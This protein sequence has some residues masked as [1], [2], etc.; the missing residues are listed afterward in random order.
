MAINRELYKWFYDHVWCH[1]YDLVV[2]WCFLPLGGEKKVRRKLVDAIDLQTA[3][4]ILDMCCGTGSTTFVL[5]EHAGKK[6][7][8]KAIDLSQGQ[9]RVA[10]K[11]NR[12]DNISF[13]AM[14]SAHTDFDDGSFD[15]VVIAH[16]LHE[17]PRQSRISV[18]R[19]A[20]RV[21]ND[22]GRLVVFEM[23]NPPS[24]LMRMFIGFWWFYWLPFNFETPTR[25]EM[26]KHGLDNEISEA[27]FRDITKRSLY[28][29][30]LQ[31][32][33]AKK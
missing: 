28:N 6:S 10:Q 25:R 29:G 17:M 13:E 19:E 26:L 7:K 3:D 24:S 14:D 22:G 8:I 20:K 15:V 27:G 31:A 12:Y 32:I 5:A 21:L 1:L 4:N 23:D 9:I 16:A 2:W 11:R 18:L 30:S 33:Q